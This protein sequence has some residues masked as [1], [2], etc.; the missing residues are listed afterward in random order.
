[1]YSSSDQ[2]RL[3]NLANTLKSNSLIK[4]SKEELKPLYE[5]LK[6]AEWRYYVESD[7]ILSDSE[8]DLLFKRLKDIEQDFPE[9]ISLDSPTQRVATGMAEKSETVQHLV[10]MLSLDNTYN[11]N[12][13][14]E[15]ANRCEVTLVGQ[16]IAYTVEPKYDGASISV[17]Y[18]NHQLTRAATRGDGVYG[19]NITTIAKQIKSLPLSANFKDDG[20]TQ[21]E[22]R[23]EVI[24][25]KSTFESLNIQRIKEGLSP[26][27]NPRNAASGSL[28]ILDIAEVASRKLNVILY[29][30]SD[31]S[32]INKNNNQ[33]TLQTHS[34][35]LEWL[36]NLGF[37]TSFNNLKVFDNIK[38][39]IQYCHDFELKRDELP[40][41]I[42]G[43][44]IKVNSIQ[45][46]EILGMTAHHP[47]WAVAYKFKARQATS[48]L[49]NVEFQVGR[50]GSI[51]PVAKIEP[52][53][54]GGAMISSVSLF[55]Q[56]IVSEKDI[57]IGDIVLVERAGDVIPNIVKPIIESRNGKEMPIAFPTHCP[58]CNELLDKP[59]GEAVWRCINID[60]KA[61]IIER[62]IHFCSKDAMD[63]RGMGE[64][65]VQRLYNANIIQSIA[66]LYKI[67]WS[68][69]AMLEGFKDKTIANL[70]QAIEISKSQSLNRLIFGLGIRHV[71]ET[72]AKN[73]AR[74]VNSIKDFFE[75][76]E[77][78]LL[79]IDDVGTKL[80]ASITHFFSLSENRQLIQTLA[81][82]GVNTNNIQQAVQGNGLAG[83]TFLF[84]GTLTK[85]KRS[86]AESL[87]DQ[88]GATILSSVSTKLDYLV[89][90]ESAGSKLEKAKKIGTIKIL[91]EQS[92]LYM[93]QALD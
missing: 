85:F 14:N 69:V 91:D 56:D 33:Q 50:T 8:Y 21:I 19:E 45:Q 5:V 12:D 74:K 62:I 48:K 83:K 53:N 93:L 67:D 28:R 26:L 64:A 9:L 86:E 88:K 92:F 6:Y 42:D 36:Y 27:A 63:I 15:W 23:G 35:S 89:V 65:N 32:F 76:S 72:I 75:I 43:M 78:D 44:V 10:P 59:E 55:N 52:V 31:V 70:K 46:Q 49:L 80:A 2:K 7:P 84:T 13:L 22:I 17:I 79:Q 73:L 66:D 71:G 58:V 40:Y 29:H 57:R 18:N 87:V 25:L 61:Q 37:P 1:M 39:V 82:L 24:M 68:K 90:G 20:I 38:D 54:I 41:E 34:I 81:D 3:I 51:T 30:I 11:E 60:C 77:N 47:R 16:K 4:P